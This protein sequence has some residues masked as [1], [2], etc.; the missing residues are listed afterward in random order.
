M[1]IV[2]LQYLHLH[3]QCTCIPAQS[4]TSETVCHKLDLRTLDRTETQYTF[5]N[6]SIL[7]SMWLIHKMMPK[8][9]RDI[10]AVCPLWHKL[11]W[12]SLP[13]R[14]FPTQAMGSWAGHGN[15]T[16]WYIHQFHVPYKLSKL[17]LHSYRLV[18]SPTWS[19]QNED[20]FWSI[21]ESGRLWTLEGMTLPVPVEV[22]KF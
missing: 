6:Y 17:R 18:F 9:H 2:T 16:N 13:A 11:T 21:S 12:E 15:D 10:V 22:G 19:W 14:P 3:V 4:R 5:V 20:Q 1:R 7:K 8:F